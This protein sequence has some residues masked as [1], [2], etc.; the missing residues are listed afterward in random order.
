[1]FFFE[2]LAGEFG[3]DLAGEFGSDLAGE[4]RYLVSSFGVREWG[5]PHGW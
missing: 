4:S 5:G 3:S 2:C 1:M